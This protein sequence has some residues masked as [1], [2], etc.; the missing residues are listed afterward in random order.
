MAGPEGLSLKY[1][2]LIRQLSLEEFWETLSEKDRNVFRN[3]CKRSFGILGFQLEGVDSSDSKLTT[4]RDASSF[5]IGIAN[6]TFEMEKYDL[7][8]KLLLKA[9]ELA[10]DISQIHSCYIWL[11]KLHYKNRFHK[12]QS[13]EEC[14]YYCKSD[15]KIL[16][17]L[18]NEIESTSQNYINMSCFRVLAALYEELQLKI[19]KEQ[20]LELEQYYR[21][22][23]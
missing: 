18:I 20:V 19:E 10:K 2:G 9:I 6:W 14:I 4:R 17:I 12:S 11:I 8:E 7:T 23:I 22:L 16:P 5:L 1:G 13:T 15:I 21:S 3:V